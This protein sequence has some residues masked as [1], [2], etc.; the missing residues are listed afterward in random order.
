MGMKWYLIVDLVYMSLMIRNCL[1]LFGYL[2]FIYI[3]PLKSL[4]KA[5]SLI[6]MFGFILLVWGCRSSFYILSI[7][8]ISDMRLENISPHTMGCLFTQLIVFFG[9]HKF[10]NLIKSN[11][12]IVSFVASY[13]FWGY[14]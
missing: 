9:I 12:S 13:I 7:N 14:I 5:L 2:L 3:H 4:L 8:L 1:H 11:L 6:G 10:L